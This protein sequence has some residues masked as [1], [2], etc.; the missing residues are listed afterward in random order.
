MGALAFLLY[1]NGIIY[2]KRKGVHVESRQ[3]WGIGIGAFVG[4][5]LGGVI[6][7]VAGGTGI[8]FYVGIALGAAIGAGLG[9]VLVQR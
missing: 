6:F 2:R 3:A 7:S 1:Y 5:V 9:G 8:V 4:A